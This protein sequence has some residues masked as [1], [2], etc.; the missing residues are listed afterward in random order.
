MGSCCLRWLEVREIVNEPLVGNNRHSTLIPLHASSHDASEWPRNN[1]T[2]YPVSKE[3]ELV[4][5]VYLAMVLPGYTLGTGHVLLE[6]R[7]CPWVT[8]K[9]LGQEINVLV[10]HFLCWNG[11]RSQLQNLIS[12]SNKLVL[13]AIFFAIVNRLSVDLVISVVV[14]GRHV[15]RNN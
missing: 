8:S 13:L 5:L 3:G 1:S 12:L 6:A 9:V 14:C 15:I 7:S 11:W 4:L 10:L 2:E